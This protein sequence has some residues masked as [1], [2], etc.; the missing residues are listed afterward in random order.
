MHHFRLLPRFWCE[1][2]FP[3]ESG[4]GF[5]LRCFVDHTFLDGGMK[6]VH[7][8]RPSEVVVR[9]PACRTLAFNVH[10]CI[11]LH[12]L[13]QVDDAVVEVLLGEE[14]HEGGVTRQSV[15]AVVHSGHHQA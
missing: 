5:R 15:T 4:Y 10:R 1:S 6:D 11:P 9:I 8:V 7:A 12:A 2:R 13:E 14:V 3:G